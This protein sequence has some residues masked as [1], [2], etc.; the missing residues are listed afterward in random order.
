MKIAKHI[1]T[2]LSFLILFANIGLAF[3][4]H[5]CHGNVSGVSL[6]YKVAKDL[7]KESSGCCAK[8]VEAEKK[9]CKD[10]LVK[11][12]K[13]T[14]PGVVKSISME[15][16]SFFSVA[17]WKPSS[18]FYSEEPVLVKQTPSFYCDANAPPLF[19]LYCQYIFY[20]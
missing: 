16:G 19:K 4:V 20:A 13:K 5:Y 10:S 9:C 8:K 6:T 18:L 3:N 12:E 15:L 1:S 7:S 2:L 17:D 14:D 11:L